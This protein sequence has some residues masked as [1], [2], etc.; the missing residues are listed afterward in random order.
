MTALAAPPKRVTLG[1]RVIR[2]IEAYCVIPD[3]PQ[4]GQPFIVPD[5]WRETIC[6]WYEVVPDGIGGTRRRYSQGLIG[7]AKKNIKTSVAA[8]M[9]LYELAGSEDPAALVLSAASTE[10]QGSNLLYGSA[11]TMVMQSPQLTDALIALD[12]E[13]TVPSQPRARMR[14]LTN[15]AGSQDGLN[16]RAIFADE[17]HE[18]TGTS[19]RRLF[20]VLEG[21]LASRPDATLLGI[22]TAGYDEDS[23]CYE[24]YEYGKKVELGLIWDPR[25]YFKWLEAPEGCDHKDPRM[26]IIPN[27]LLGVSVFESVLQDRLLRDPESVFR[28]YHLNQWVAGEDI[29][30]PS[31]LWDAC[32]HPEIGLRT[33]LPVH[34]MIDVGIRHDSSAVAL[35]QRQTEI[36]ETV[37][38]ARVWENPYPRDHSLH[39]T[40][41]L[42]IEEV[43]QY[44][45]DVR[46]LYP[47]ATAEVDGELMPGPEFNYD[48][49]NF[50]RS[51]QMLS[52]EG[53]TMVEYPQN[54][55]RMVPAS[56]CLH[57]VVVE[58][59]IAHD[60]DPILRRHI[61]SA[62]ADQKARGWR[63]SK[64][65]GSLR[66][67]DAAIATAVA[68]YM[69]QAADPIGG[70]VYEE[71]GIAFI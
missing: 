31:S 52:G 12:K 2:W 39:D 62:I 49:W 56:Q 65:K 64:P 8:A 14:N 18:W 7:V 22:T 15:K 38:R 63:L 29:W 51:A 41:S 11:K 1:P 46:E 36:D 60:G 26:W 37:V 30:I 58:G 67:I 23:L 68:V 59:K 69:A 6:E 57:D 5:W 42:N 20:A 33:D 3:G 35:A 19:G 70:S 55:S 34:V 16:A 25:F 54:D 47:E 13:I 24:K 10:D 61:L 53:L 50:E 66:K 17:L 4:I 9:A 71:R 45:R 40:W 48:P 32:K 28:R 21:A 44:L 27:P 43:E